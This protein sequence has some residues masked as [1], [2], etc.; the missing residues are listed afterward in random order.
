M[1][2]RKPGL[3]YRDL[4]KFMTE[5]TYLFTDESFVFDEPG[6]GF[7]NKNPSGK[8]K[9][10]V[11]LEINDSFLVGIFCHTNRSILLIKSND[12]Y[13]IKVNPNKRKE[14]SECLLLPLN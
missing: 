2:C 6:E 11:F 13:I 1:D 12:L 9:Q 10:F 3:S 14:A 8:V 4:E 5:E 7:E